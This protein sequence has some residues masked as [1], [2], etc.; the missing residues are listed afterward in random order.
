MALSPNGII[1]GDLPAV[2]HAQ[3][4]LV[5]A[6][7][8]V[9]GVIAVGD[10][11]AFHAASRVRGQLLRAATDLERSARVGHFLAADHV[12]GAAEA[13]RAARLVGRAM[14]RSR[15]VDPVTGLVTLL[16]AYRAARGSIEAAF[17]AAYA[18]THP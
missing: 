12:H 11:T 1:V 13:R 6:R 3:R 9:G 8:L 10:T 16:A 15:H 17:R 2:L 4:R 18:G 5:D 7:L 14:V